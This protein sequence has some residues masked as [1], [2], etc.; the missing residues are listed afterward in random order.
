MIGQRWF[1]GLTLMLSSCMAVN[2]QDC[3]SGN[4]EDIMQ[5]KSKKP[6]QAPPK[7]E[8]PMDQ[9]VDYDANQGGED[10]NWWDNKSQYLLNSQQL[11]EG[12]SLCDDLFHNQSPN[13]DGNENDATMRGKPGFLDYAHQGPE[14]PKKDLEEF[15]IL[16]LNLANIELH[17]PLDASYD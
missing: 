11:V 16:V 1:T 12:L 8:I 15:Q 14:D 5:A 4:G 6:S 9:V 17:I 13:Q 7:V 10:P 2:E 3:Y